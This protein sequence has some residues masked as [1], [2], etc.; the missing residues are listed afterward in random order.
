MC[1]LWYKE[2]LFIHSITKKCCLGN[3]AKKCRSFIAQIFLDLSKF[4]AKQNFC[5]CACIH[6]TPAPAPPAP[7]PPA[8]TPLSTI[9]IKN[10]LTTRLPSLLQCLTCEFLTSPIWNKSPSYHD[11]CVLW[12]CTAFD[13]FF[14][15]RLMT[16]ESTCS[17][18]S[19]NFD[20]SDDYHGYDH[21]DD[22]DHNDDYDHYDDYDRYV[23]H[24]HWQLRPRWRKRCSFLLTSVMRPPNKR[25]LKHQQCFK[26]K[27]EHAV[28]G[29]VAQT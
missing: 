25:E 29:A 8:L 28:S 13:I 20:E 26:F 24:D 4:L 6:S 1:F 19:R 3:I 7:A 2:L 18:S 11:C 15:C 21:Y 12:Q 9:N 27:S 14:I 22:Y 10:V 23:D 5:W 16:K 17:D